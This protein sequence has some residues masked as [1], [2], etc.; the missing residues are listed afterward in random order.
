VALSVTAAVATAK[1]ADLSIE[2][3]RAYEALDR[4][5]EKDAAAQKVRSEADGDRKPSILD[6]KHMAGMLGVTARMRDDA[7]GNSTPVER[8]A[9]SGRIKNLNAIDM[10]NRQNLGE[11]ERALNEEIDRQKAIMSA[12]DSVLPRWMRHGTSIERYNFADG[13]L[14][15]LLGAKEELAWFKQD[16]QRYNERIARDE[17][18]RMPS[19]IAAHT[20]APGSRAKT[21]PDFNAA[22]AGVSAAPPSDEQPPSA[23]SVR[24]RPARPLTPT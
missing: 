14:Q 15:N 13:E 8:Y 24:Q 23:A 11:Y 20:Q 6:Y 16:L 10:T 7:L 1:V 22:V 17:T 21:A 2:N 9:G 5:V 4:A 18:A 3:H 12:N 19:S